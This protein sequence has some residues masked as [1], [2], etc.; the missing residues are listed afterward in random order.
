MKPEQHEDQSGWL[1]YIPVAGLPALKTCAGSPLSL[2][3]ARKY[4]CGYAELVRI[5]TGLAVLIDE[6]G[7]LK[8]LPINTLASRIAGTTIAGPAIFGPINNMDL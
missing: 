6:D 2:E 3:D 4:L 7:Q 8:G 1:L 5:E